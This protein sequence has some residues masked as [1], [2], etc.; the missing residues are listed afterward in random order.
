M[1]LFL[2]E[3]RERGMRLDKFLVEKLGSSMS[4]AKIQKAI[5]E[6][7]WTVDGKEV[8]VHHFLKAGQK[9]EEA[10][11]IKEMSEE[12]S[13]DEVKVIAETEDYVVIDKP[14]GVAVHPAPGIDEPTVVEMLADRY[15]ELYSVG[16][17]PMRPGVVHRI[18]KLVSG[19]LV[20]AR[21][22][23]T[24][25]HLKRQFQSRE[26]TKQYIALVQ[27]TF[28]NDEGVIDLPLVRSTTKGKR[29][30]IQALPL[31]GKSQTRA[32]WTQTNAERSVDN[33][34]TR[35]AVTKFEVAKRF[36]RFTLLRVFPETGRTHQIRAHF[37]AIGHPIAGDPLYH[38]SRKYKSSF[39]LTRPFLHASSI[40][41]V[42]REG[43]EQ[44]YPSPL[45]HMLRV[46]VDG[47][48]G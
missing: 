17:D 22:Q 6:G 7:Q 33:R 32:D 13:L 25:T 42:D 12:T 35:E 15:P 28:V 37:A 16:E 31:A 39:I 47:L 2:V 45:P 4:R 23:A 21:N 1:H 30:K 46:I 3:E 29:G 10:K 20:L 11:G 8:S 34:K 9:V 19:A 18:D 27:G 43:N 38:G 36:P 5:E 48:G 24:F 40:S 44:T 26:V 14:S 41:F